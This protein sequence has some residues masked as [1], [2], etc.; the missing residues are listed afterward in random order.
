MIEYEKLWRRLDRCL[1]QGWHDSMERSNAAKWVEE[2][3][4]DLP[5]WRAAVAGL[6][7]V[8]SARLGIERGAVTLTS[9]T[10]VAVQSMGISAAGA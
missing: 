8:N 6:P 3:H 4:G 1:P 5:R 10:A 7:E 9:L 2:R